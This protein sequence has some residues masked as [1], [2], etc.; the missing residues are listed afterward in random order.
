MSFEPV[1]ALEDD[2][3]SEEIKKVIWDCLVDKS[4]VADGFSFDFIRRFW[5]LMEPDFVKAVKQ[6]F[7]SSVFPNGCNPSFIALIPKVVGASNV[8]EF[9]PISFIGFQYKI[10]GK[11]LANWL[12]FVVDNF[13]SKELSRSSLLSLNVDKSLGTLLL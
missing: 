4:L 8:K 6:F 3:S 12:S 2:V 1:A 10:V 13:V 7:P 11:V 9:R 5:Y